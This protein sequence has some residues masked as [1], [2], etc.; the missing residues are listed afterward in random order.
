VVGGDTGTAE[1]S[2]WWDAHVVIATMNSLRNTVSVRDF[3]VAVEI[4]SK[5]AVE[6]LARVETKLIDA[7]LNED[8][9]R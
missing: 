3:V 8:C 1:A 7:R 5:I 4:G 6:M 2:L 9:G